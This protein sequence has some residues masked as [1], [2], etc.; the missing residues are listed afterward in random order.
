ML[1]GERNPEALLLLCDERIKKHKAAE[2]LKALEGNSNM[3]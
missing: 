3:L 2:V 1:Q